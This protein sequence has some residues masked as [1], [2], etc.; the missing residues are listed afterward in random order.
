MAKKRQGPG[1]ARVVKKNGQWML[2][3]WY[4]GQDVKSFPI[5]FVNED[6]VITQ[7]FTSQEE[8]LV[9]N[10]LPDIALSIPTH[11]KFIRIEIEGKRGNRN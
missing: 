9:N 3:A 8:R 4:L 6:C 7:V 1:I 5:A 10:N 11:I 2:K